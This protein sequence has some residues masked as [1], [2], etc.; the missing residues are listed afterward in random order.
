MGKDLFDA[1]GAAREVFEEIDEAL[2]RK[3]SKI[4]FEGPADELTLTQNAQPALMAV[5]L[6][7]TRVLKAEAG[8]DVGPGAAF[9]AGH[10]LGEYSALCAADCL[11]L[12]DTAVL[13]EKRGQAMQRAV[14]VGE[15]AMIAVLGLDFD[16]AAEVAALAAQEIGGDAVCATANDNGA[17]QVVLSGHTAAIARAAEL[18]VE[19]GAKRAMDLPVSAPFHCSLMS[20]AAEEMATA[21][22]EVTIAPPKAPLIA[23]VT[24]QPVSDPDQIR[25]LLIEQITSMVRWRET[26]EFLAP[27]GVE[28]VVELGAGKVLSGL[29]RRINRDLKPITVSGPADIE[30]FVKT[31]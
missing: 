9:V 2:G 7:V 24:A 14:P 17:G 23:N 31:I 15:G 29:A 1:F 10:S 21:L 12:S 11:N 30:T 22:A 13:L 26:I 18:A 19:N 28:T 3:L 20:P 25:G 6:A 8:F 5:S 4:V 16:A 27:N